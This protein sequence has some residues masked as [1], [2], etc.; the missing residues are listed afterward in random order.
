MTTYDTFVGYFGLTYG[1]DG[2]GGDKDKYRLGWDANRA[3]LLL[4]A[5]MKDLEEMEVE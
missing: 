5:G 2:E 1:L 4:L 3:Q